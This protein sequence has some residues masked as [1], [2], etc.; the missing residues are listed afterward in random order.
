MWGRDGAQVDYLI[1]HVQPGS[2]VFVLSGGDHFWLA[3]LTRR[4]PELYAS[5]LKCILQTQAL[6]WTARH[7][8]YCSKLAYYCIHFASVGF[9]NDG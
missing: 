1:D 8:H 4:A 3:E 7:A 9:K 2:K 5:F 6:Q